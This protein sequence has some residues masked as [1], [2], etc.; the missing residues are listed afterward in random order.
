[1]TGIEDADTGRISVP[2]SA[3]E[4]YAYCPRQSALIHVEAAWSENVHTVG[5]TIAHQAVDLPGRQRRAGLTTVRA[6]PVWS[7][8]HGLHGVCDL[9]ELHGRAALP[10]EY[11]VGKYERDGPA[12]VQLAGQV[13]CL[14]EMGYDVTEGAIYSAAERRRHP[15]R[16]T[17]DL[18]QRAIYT[19]EEMRALIAAY[20]VPPAVNDRRCRR[21]SLRDDCL[22]QVTHTA[23]HVDDS[24]LFT[25]H[26][27]GT[28]ND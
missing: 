24:L 13:I 16:M 23:G 3:L 2:L 14:R 15:V 10:V 27:L 21:C 20:A 25:P 7:H 19:A 17:A 18:I 26:G 1:V 6:L 4:H 9:V 11:K 28:W 5:G 12:D 22:P 8:V